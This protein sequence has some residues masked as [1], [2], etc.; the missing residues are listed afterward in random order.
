M[1]SQA[2][3]K[4]TYD[5]HIK[6]REFY[7]GE[8]ALV[9]DLIK[10]QTWWPGSM[11]ERG[12]PKS[13]VVA[14]KDGRVWK[15]Q[16]DHIKRNTMDSVLF[17]DWRGITE[18]VPKHCPKPCLT[19]NYGCRYSFTWE[20]AHE[21]A[22]HAAGWFWNFSSVGEWEYILISKRPHLK[23]SGKW[24]GFHCASLV[25]CSRRWTDW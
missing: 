13:Y 8:R 17:G 14:L 7:P 22:S 9:R 24:S 4:A 11:A 25:E 2:T 20:A 3:Q 15:R 1:D 18:P 6:F 5:A 23:W 12:E 19:I 21:H 10:K 16:L